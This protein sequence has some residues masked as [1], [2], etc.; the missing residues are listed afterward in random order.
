MSKADEIEVKKI[1]GRVRRGHDRLVDGI[2]TYD[3][4]AM[5]DDLR[6]LLAIIKQLNEKTER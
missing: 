6:T 5:Y 2:N 3:V 1:Q 4:A